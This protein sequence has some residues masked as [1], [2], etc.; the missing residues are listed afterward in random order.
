MASR[1]FHDSQGTSR[2]I[3]YMDGSFAPAG[4]GAPTDPRGSGFTASRTGVGT[5]LLTLADKYASLIG[6]SATVGL[7]SSADTQAQLG[8]VVTG[9]AATN[10]VVIRTITA[11]SDADISAD[12]NN[13]V[14]FQLA[15]QNTSTPGS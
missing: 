2:E 3:K 13:R 15:L 5:F 7:A 4:T 9:G 14:F 11:G 6:A 1:L 12:A 10:T 8:T